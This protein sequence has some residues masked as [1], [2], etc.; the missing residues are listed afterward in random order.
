MLHHFATATDNGPCVAYWQGQ[1]VAVVVFECITPEQAE[2][3][4]ERLNIWGRAQDAHNEQKAQAARATT[5][6]ASRYFEPDAFA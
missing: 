1:G 2:R 3:E 4:A 5:R 6:R